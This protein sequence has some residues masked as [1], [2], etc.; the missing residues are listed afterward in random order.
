MA[1][2]HCGRGRV[3][4][5]CR[6]RY[7]WIIFGL[8]GLD[9]HCS[10][11]A[12]LLVVVYLVGISGA[13]WPFGISFPFDVFAGVSWLSSSQVRFQSLWKSFIE[14]YFGCEL[15]SK[16]LE[17]HMNCDLQSSFFTKFTILRHHFSRN[18][19]FPTLIFHK[20]HNFKTKIF[21]KIQTIIL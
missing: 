7:Y 15:E 14:S 6:T 20:I 11:I 18:S 13:E 5:P 1:S 3:C 17:I 16:M 2:S 10:S 19:R 8:F 9:D 4:A 12:C 21:H